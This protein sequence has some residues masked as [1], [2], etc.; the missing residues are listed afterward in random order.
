MIIKIGNEE[1][2]CESFERAETS[3]KLIGTE[4]GTIEYVGINWDVVVFPENV[5]IPPSQEERIT[6]IENLLLEIV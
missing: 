2:T 5:I 1:I 3:L 6:A 4:N